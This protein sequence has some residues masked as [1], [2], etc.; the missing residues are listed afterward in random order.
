MNTGLRA[1]A[2][3]APQSPV[4]A[5]CGSRESAPR[6]RG[7]GSPNRDWARRKGASKELEAGVRPGPKPSPP[8]T[9]RPSPLRAR[10]V[11]G[12]SGSRADRRCPTRRPHRS[13]GRS[14]GHPPP[15]GRPWARPDGYSCW[16]PERCFDRQRDR[17]NMRSPTPR[18]PRPGMRGYSAPA[19][20]VRHPR[21]VRGRRDRPGTKW[22]RGWWG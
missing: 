21:P 1:G 15:A 16:S 2:V 13:R 19:A 17:P 9:D 7:H 18:T 6:R 3:I 12:R 4:A 8:R 5:A 20:P 10:A 11:S 14:P 22:L